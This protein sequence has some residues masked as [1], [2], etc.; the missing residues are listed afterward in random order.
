MKSSPLFFLGLFASLAFSLTALVLATN[1]QYGNLAPFAD[2]TVGA[3]F[4]QAPLGLAARGHMVYRDLGCAAC[5]TQQ[6]RRSR[7]RTRQGTRLGRPPE[8]RARLRA[9]REDRVLLGEMRIGPDLTNFGARAAAHGLSAAQLL[10]FL[11]N[12]Q[13][14]MPAYPFLFRE[15]ARHRSALARGVCDFGLAGLRAC[16]HAP[17]RGA[18]GLPAQLERRPRISGDQAGR[19]ARQT[20]RDRCAC[21]TGER[22]EMSTPLNDPRHEQA[23]LS[24]DSLLVVHEKIFTEKPDMEGGYSALP[25]ALLFFFS[26]LIFFSGT[27]LN[28]FS[29]GFSAMIYNENLRLVIGGSAVPKLDPVAMGKIAF[30]TPGA[31]VTCHQPNGQGIPGVYP[32]LAGSGGWAQGSPDRVVRIVMFGLQG[33]VHVRGADFSA[34]RHAGLWLD[35]DLRLERRENRQR[36]DVCAPGVGQ[37]GGA[38]HD[39]TGCGH[40]HRRSQPHQG[41][42]PGRI[43]ED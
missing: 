3:A 8:R 16:A 15:A 2:A 27:Y 36:T 35:R 4:P 21:R 6:V 10:A 22:D 33:P 34:R 13:G 42:D 25:L 30:N 24:D 12:G 40:S 29:G 32:P 38:D 19:T 23:A 14:A 28:R 31:C 18:R 11:H 43:T 41:V 26:A 9:C 39:R 7:F 37:Q 1:A 20:C 5:H 17:R